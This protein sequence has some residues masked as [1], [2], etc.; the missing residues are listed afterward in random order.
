MPTIESN[1]LTIAFDE[2]GRGNPRPLLLVQGLGGQLIHWDDAF[3]HRLADSG[4]H[5]IR[6]DN[7]DAGCSSVLDHLGVPDVEEVALR[8]FSGEPVV[9]PYSMDDMADDAWGLLDALG[10]TRAHLC[11]VSLGGMIVQVMAIRAPERALSL[12]SISASNGDPAL[13]TPTDAALGAL[14][15]P[16]G[17][18]RDGAIARSVAYNRVVGSPAYPASDATLE[19]RAAAT[20]DRAHHPDGGLRQLAALI[21]HGNRHA[22]LSELNVPALVIHGKDDPLMPLAAGLATA[23]AL[24]ARLLAVEGMGHDVPEPLW[25]AIVDAITARTTEE[26]DGGDA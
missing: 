11:G 13:L 2:I 4:H 20:Y 7:R 9:P 25:P 6:F 26:T 12:T 19:R 3:C 15:A 24:G 5:V 18:D 23:E 8:F 21:G 1:G 17:V 22:A 14:M 10:V 16:A